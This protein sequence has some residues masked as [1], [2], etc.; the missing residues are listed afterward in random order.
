[1][2][3]CCWCPVLAAALL[4]SSALLGT[5]WAVKGGCSSLTRRNWG[6][7]SVITTHS[8]LCATGE[9]HGER[10]SCR[11]GLSRSGIFEG[12]KHWRRGCLTSVA[13]VEFVSVAVQHHSLAAAIACTILIAHQS[14]RCWSVAPIAQPS[15]SRS[16]RTCQVGFHSH[17]A[18]AQV[19]APCIQ[20]PPFTL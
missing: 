12:A 5:S 2:E 10:R 19:R 1:M 18:A 6:A 20:H 9:V 3:Q 16:H 8:R 13:R 7:E 17:T 14:R 4:W 11:C 15:C